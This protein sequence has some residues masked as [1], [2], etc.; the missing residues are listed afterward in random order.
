MTDHGL[1]QLLWRDRWRG[2]ATDAVADAVVNPL[3]VVQ[4]AGGTT[5]Y[6]GERANV[7]LNQDGILVT[8]YAKRVD[9]RRWRFRSTTR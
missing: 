5:L 7:V 2:V 9:G 8:A 3:A 6:K 4:Q 1:D